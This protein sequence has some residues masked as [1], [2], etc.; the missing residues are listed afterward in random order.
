MSLIR[1]LPALALFAA[2]GAA[3]AT[4]P[5]V[6][7]LVARHV[8]ALGG[9][10]KIHAIRSI[11]KHGWYEEGDF[12]LDHTFTAQMR[13]F[14]RV[15]GDTRERPLDG[16]HEG[17]DGSSWEYYPDPGLVVRTVGAAAR[18]TRNSASFEDVLT[19]YRERGTTLAYQGTSTFHDRPVYVLHYRRADGSEGECML[20]RHTYMIDGGRALLFMHAF[21]KKYSTDQVYGDYRAE[22]GVM[23]AHSDAEIDATTGKILDKGGVA[24]I[25]INP[26]LPLSMF[27]PPTWNRTPLQQMIQRIYDE[28]DEPAAVMATYRDFAQLLDMRAPATGDAVDFVGYQCLKMG[29]TDTTVALLSQN[30]SDHPASARAHFGLGRAYASA[31]ETAKAKGEFSRALS[32]DPNFL[33][34]RTALEAL[35]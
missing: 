26:D 5:S 14:Y 28:R 19:D 23:F 30:V 1:L 32:I 4:Q 25:E 18:T 33:R 29:H 20:D 6:E 9:I 10:D 8:A 12:R 2:L 35:K 16:I 7:D 22:G 15:I 17:Y 27:S 24:S 21:G 3:P 31:G 11:I 34:A 13:P